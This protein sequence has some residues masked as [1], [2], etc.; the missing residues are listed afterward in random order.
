MT[1]KNSG[2]KAG[3]ELL[4][5]ERREETDARR[6]AQALEELRRRTRRG[7]GSRK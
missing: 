6:L 1:E 2:S 5:P 4:W 7:Y 3:A